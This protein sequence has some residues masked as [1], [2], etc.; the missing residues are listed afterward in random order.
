MV[1][2]SRDQSYPI[3]SRVTWEY[4]WKGE[5][6]EEFSWTLVKTG[7]GP[8]EA[9]RR[10]GSIYDRPPKTSVDRG[11]MVEAKET[12]TRLG[13][14]FKIRYLPRDLST[15]VPLMQLTQTTLSG[16]RVLVSP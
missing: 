2:A 7:H 6:R 9:D 11:T 12:S 14:P 3:F 8:P 13:G 10:P 4:I 1:H 15:Q 5:V 16:I